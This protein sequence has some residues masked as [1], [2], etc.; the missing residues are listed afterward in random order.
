MN[1]FGFICKLTPGPLGL[2]VLVSDLRSALDYTKLK[3]FYSLKS[4]A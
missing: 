1:L 2:E 4:E 3:H